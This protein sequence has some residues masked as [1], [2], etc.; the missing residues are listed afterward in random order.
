MKFE[1]MNGSEI[2]EIVHCVLARCCFCRILLHGTDNPLPIFTRTLHRSHLNKGCYGM[3]PLL[4]VILSI[5]M[6]IYQMDFCTMYGNP[7][8]ISKL[9]KLL[10]KGGCN[11]P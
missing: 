6:L 7:F 1:D 3:L 10:F 4:N 5:L 11:I 2:E 8:G 9:T